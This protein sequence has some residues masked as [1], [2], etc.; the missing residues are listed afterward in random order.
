ML[1]TFGRDHEQVG[2][3]ILRDHDSIR[4]SFEKII[5]SVEAFFVLNKGFSFFLDGKGHYQLLLI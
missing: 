3:G 5:A 4:V 1:L 2:V